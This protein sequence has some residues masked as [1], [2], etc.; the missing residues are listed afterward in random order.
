M[1]NISKISLAAVLILPLIACGPQEE[2]TGVI[3]QG[4]LDAIDKTKNVENI[5]QDAQKQ[6]LESIEE[7][8]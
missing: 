6:Q 7:A 3:S 2:P 5:L 4:H 1:A 8:R